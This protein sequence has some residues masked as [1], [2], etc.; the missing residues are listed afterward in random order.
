MLLCLLLNF[1]SCSNFDKGTKSEANFRGLVCFD[2]SV[3]FLFMGLASIYFLQGNQISAYSPDSSPATQGYGAAGFF[4]LFATLFA[5][6]AVYQFRRTE[7]DKFFYIF[8]ISF[9]LFCLSSMSICFAFLDQYRRN[10]RID[11][12]DMEFTHGF[13]GV[14]SFLG[15][16]VNMVAIF[17]AICKNNPNYKAGFF[18]ISW[19]C[20]CM[21]YAALLWS[22]CKIFET[23]GDDGCTIDT[24]MNKQSSGFQAVMLLA[25]ACLQLVAAFCSESGDNENPLRPPSY[26]KQNDI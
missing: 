23:C 8:F 16:L 22:M 3:T 14:M 21:Y 9:A 2:L 4:T 17:N 26:G 15:A 18:L 25:G 13:A 10:N 6:G 5:L 19:T 11:L 1:L 12:G 24:D 20:F 7:E